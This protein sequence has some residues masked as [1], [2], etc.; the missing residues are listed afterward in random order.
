MQT[1]E[2]SSTLIPGNEPDRAL[3]EAP[4]Y[5]LSYRDEFWASRAYEDM[6]DRIA[7]R[8][9]LPDSGAHLLDL[10]A[11]FGRL[12]DEYGHFERVT[13][14]DASPSMIEAARERVGVNPRV[15]V[16][17]A[18]AT[19]LPI[20]TGSIDVV[21][22]VRLMVHLGHPEAVFAEVARV[23]RPGGLF[24]VEFPNRRHLL[25]RLRYLARRQSWSP[26]GPEPHEYREGHFSHQP[27]TV[28]RA[29]R[30]AGLVPTERR[31][32]SMFRSTRLKQAV[33]ARL[34]AGLEAPLQA[35]LG[36][37]APTPS[38]YIAS[39]NQGRTLVAG[40]PGEP[41]A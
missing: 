40:G 3:P 22:S 1:I 11:G 41:G 26:S 29:L 19:A 15:S 31:A 34:L 10:G 8:A 4:I 5:D 7:I 6:C 36:R 18:D 23:L 38:I 20:E 21:V 27:V 2:S 32:V 16:V 37:L 39:R 33:P 24:I 28:V 9:L 30:R 25:A 35:R 13:L 12:V 14:V 17:L